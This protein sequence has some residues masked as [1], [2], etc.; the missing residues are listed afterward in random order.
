VREQ[1]LHLYDAERAA[2][3]RV[4]QPVVVLAVHATHQRESQQVVVLAEH[5]YYAC[6]GQ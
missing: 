4:S 5:S 6:F 3:R 2:L 1:S